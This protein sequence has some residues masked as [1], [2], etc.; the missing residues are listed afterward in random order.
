MEDVFYRI[1]EILATITGFFCVYFEMKQKMALWYFGIISGCLFFM[2]FFH[3]GFYAYALFQVGF[4]ATSV[5]GLLQ[6]KE[7]SKEHGENA[8]IS[9]VPSKLLFVLVVTI[10]ALIIGLW[11]V[12]L[13]FN[14]NCTYA[15]LDAFISTFSI[16]ATWMLARK[17]IEQW[18]AWIIADIVSVG[19]F[20]TDG[21]YPTSVLYTIYVIMSVTG[22]LLWR[23]DLKKQKQEE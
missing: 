16:L 1:V 9:R 19:V 17:Y 6:W 15:F 3:Q 21:L 4:I 18:A 14:D 13:L 23:K 7:S 20:F 2:L 22:F 8:P 5:Y 11:R 10:V 12:L